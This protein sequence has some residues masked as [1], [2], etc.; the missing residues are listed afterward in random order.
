MSHLLRL[1]SFVNLDPVVSSSVAACEFP[2]PELEV[3]FADGWLAA[4]MGRRDASSAR[5]PLQAVLMADSFAQ[6]LRPLTLERPK[7]LLPIADAPMLDYALEWLAMAGVE[8][9]YVFCCAHAKQIERHLEERKWSTPS[10]LVKTVVSTNCLSVGEAL[11]IVDQRNVI[12]GDFILLSSD[13]VS[14]VNIQEALQAHKKRR[15]ADKLA[16]MTMVTRKVSDRHRRH[17]LGCQGLTMALDPVD[18]RLL[19]YQEGTASGAQA[20]RLYPSITEGRNCVEVCTDLLDCQIDICAPEVLMLF[21]D[22]FDYQQLR[23]DFV[24]GV[25]SEEE[26]GNKIYI[27]QLNRGYA[28]QVQNL[29]T[30]DAV[31]RDIIERWTHPLVPDSNWL[32]SQ[33]MLFSQEKTHGIEDAVVKMFRGNVYKAETVKVDH[34]ATVGP[35]CYVGSRSNVGA[36]TT[37]A[38]SVIGKNCKIGGNCHLEGCYLFSNCTVGDNVTILRSLLADKVTV[39]AGAT[40]QPGCVLSFGVVIGKNHTVPSYTR[41]SLLQPVEPEG[42]SE[43]ELEY[44]RKGSCATLSVGS[45]SESDGWDEEHTGELAELKPSSAA[46]NAAHAAALRE[47]SS[48]KEEVQWDVSLV[49]QG[50]GWKWELPTGA[51]ELYSIAPP[52]VTELEDASEEDDSVVDGDEMFDLADTEGDAADGFEQGVGDLELFFRKEVTETFLRCVKEKFDQTNAVIELNALKIAEDRTFADCARYVLI[53]ILQLNLPAP[54]IISQQYASLFQQ[55]PPSLNSVAEKTSFLA[56]L[57]KRLEEWGPLL[58]RFLKSLDDQVEVLLTLEEFCGEEGVFSNGDHGKTYIPVFLLLLQL[59]YQQDIISEEA[60]LDWAREKEN[61]EEEE[62]V[63]L[64]LA[65][66]FIQWLEMAESED[67]DDDEEEDEDE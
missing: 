63:L 40:V 52:P 48:L 43:D 26:L 42:G 65:M 31:S 35:S 51:E 54:S 12:R 67:D 55:D 15:E 30:Y 58:C 33:S 56:S 47:P 61:A 45:A 21:T 4:K 1:N 8:E 23:R 2:F 5:T 57:K 7:A 3:N 44:T 39:H 41:L 19:A 27:H 59:L 36:G 34:S 49:G 10:F 25:L 29:R 24:C 62:K 37:I 22:N 60:F 50:A 6:K 16:I 9:V 13:V 14:N 64:N 46:L 17:R 32:L 66:P 20:M 11:R 38:H 28:T 18:G 53:T